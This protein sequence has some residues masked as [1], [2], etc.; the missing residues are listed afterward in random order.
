[1]TGKRPAAN[2]R[3]AGTRGRKAGK[4][5]FRPAEGGQGGLTLQTG[6][7][8]KTMALGECLGRRAEPGDVFCVCGGLG[9]GKTVLA[10]GVARGL[11]VKEVVTSPTFTLINE[12]S[13]RLPFYHLDVYRL[14]GPQEMA[15]LGYEEHFYGSG[16]TLVE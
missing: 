8:L 10:K 3:T 15:A 16:V 9:A 6:S 13:G 11:G 7:A 12:Y 1:M 4:E 5:I 2:G 14:S